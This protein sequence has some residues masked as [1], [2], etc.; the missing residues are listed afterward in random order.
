MN[1]IKNI[2]VSVL[3]SLG[4]FFS[5][6]SVG[7][8]A[9]TYTL[10]ADQLQTLEVNLNQLQENNEMLKSLLNQSN[11]DLTM[12]SEQSDELSNQIA[13]LDNQLMESQNQIEILKQQLL[14]LKQQ[15][16]AAQT[17]LQTANEELQSASESFKTYARQQ[18][19]IESQLRTQKNIWQ[20][21]GGLAIGYAVSK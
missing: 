21:I 7:F 11:Q 13:T 19:K 6:Q 15:T 14:T 8:C 5:L 3:L 17:S 12:A 10:T 2:C 18:E 16:A 20:V 4:L 9:E 1:R